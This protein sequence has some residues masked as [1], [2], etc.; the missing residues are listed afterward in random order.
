MVWTGDIALLLSPLLWAALLGVLALASGGYCASRLAASA[1]EPG[2]WTALAL[3][4]G[5]GFLA[6]ALLLCGLCGQFGAASMALVAG[7]ALFFGRR[8]LAVAWREISTPRGRGGRWV[9]AGVAAAAPAWLALYPPVTWD[10]TIY[11]LPLARSLL[12]HGRY[13]FVDN[14]RSPVFPMAAETLFA[15][16]LLVGRAST[17]HGVSLLATLATASL[18]LVWARDRFAGADRSTASV[19]WV[20]AP[21]AIW[22]GQPIVVFYAGSSF[23]D[24]VLA[25]FSTAACVVFERWRRAPASAWLLAAGGF[26]GWAAATKYLG[27][28]VVAALMLAIGWEAARGTKLRAM[29]FFGAAA[30]VAAG[31]WYAVVW[32]LSGSPL[33]PY[34]STLFEAGEW[35]GAA[36]V[37][38]VG[39]PS[40]WQQGGL[41][42][43]RLSWDLVGDRSRIGFQPPSS[44]LFVLALP[45]LLYLGW[46]RRWAR[47]WIAILGGFLLAFLAL[48]RDARYFM[49]LSPML[50]ILLVEACHDLAGRADG[51]WPAG[52]ARALARSTGIALVVVGLATAPAYSLWRLRITGPPPVSATAIDDFLAR[53]LPLYRALLFRRENGFERVP[54][55]ALHGERLHD[56]G[57]S[58]LLGDWIGPYRFTRVLPLLDRPELLTRELSAFGAEQ[59]LLPRRLV[60]AKL[61]EGIAAS[62]RFRELYRDEEGVLFALVPGAPGG[63][64]TSL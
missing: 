46:R 40:T 18:L 3:P 50:S 42:L 29:A 56:F 37:A 53:R 21:A 45:L 35:S 20:V 48:P 47:I 4:L 41:D 12:E 63:P 55:Y 22:L 52:P 11:H 5:L 57:G 51:T 27:L 54:L 58:A 19:A 13:L 31:P 14:L 6:Q 23:V 43:L 7:S 25:L 38:R 24:P 2:L 26:A 33:F 10:D 60:A 34:F 9:L 44:P 1:H 28:Y 15:P 32:G 62:P 17:A 16:A 30:A 61:V 59:L 49:L 64:G 36:A 39:F 8:W